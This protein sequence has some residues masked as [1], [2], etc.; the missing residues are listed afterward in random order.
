M[1]DVRALSAAAVEFCNVFL[2]AVKTDGREMAARYFKIFVAKMHYQYAHLLKPLL[3]IAYALSADWYKACSFVIIHHVGK[4]GITDCLA[5]L[6]WLLCIVA[7]TR[8]IW[9]Q[10]AGQE[11]L[12]PFM[13]FITIAAILTIAVVLH[14]GDSV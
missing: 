3:E 12:G 4:M 11:G 10:L 9:L 6:V 5:I 1:A 13:Q 14:M 8:G 2:H 7:I